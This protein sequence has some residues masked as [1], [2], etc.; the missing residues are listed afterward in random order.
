MLANKILRSGFA[1]Y[2]AI[3]LRVESN[4]KSMFYLKILIECSLEF[5]SKNK[6]LV[7]SNIFR[8][9]KILENIL[10]KKVC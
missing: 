7:I 8:V 5:T 6:T 1:F 2:L 4:I 3:C 10:Y 9:S